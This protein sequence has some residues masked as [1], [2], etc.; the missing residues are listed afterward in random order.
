MDNGKSGLSLLG[1]GGESPTT[2]QISAH[3]F[4]PREIHACRL[5]PHQRFIYSS[6]QVTIF[7][8]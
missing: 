4:L 8:L 2:S 5:H 3:S 1:D 7:M 6:H